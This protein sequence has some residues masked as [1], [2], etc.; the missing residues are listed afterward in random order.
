MISETITFDVF[1]YLDCSALEFPEQG[2][3]ITFD[4]FKFVCK[5]FIYKF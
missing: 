1:K 3:T 5:I 4:V 2:E